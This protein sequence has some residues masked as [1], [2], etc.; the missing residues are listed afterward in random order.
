MGPM[1]ALHGRYGS[2]IDLSDWET[3]PTKFKHV[4]AYDWHFWDPWLAQTIPTEGL[5]DLRLP[6]Y[7]LH[8]ALLPAHTL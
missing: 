7:P 5:T 4:W 3:S 6:T 8:P 1:G 2:E